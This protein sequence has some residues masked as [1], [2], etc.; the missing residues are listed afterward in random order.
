L[1]AAEDEQELCIS[2]QWGTVLAAQLEEYIFKHED[3][4]GVFRA[5]RRFMDTFAGKLN[6]VFFRL[7]IIS[8]WIL[9]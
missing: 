4:G 2:N 5:V 1:L 8:Y 7:Y 3:Q 9:R 6:R